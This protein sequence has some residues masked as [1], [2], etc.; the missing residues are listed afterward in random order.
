MEDSI[1]SPAQK[2]AAARFALECRKIRLAIANN[3]GLT[4]FEL[5]KKTKISPISSHLEKME[6]MGL[7]KQENIKEGGFS[8]AVWH[9][10][11]Q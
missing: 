8:S 4:E 9:V 11:P 2:A 5:R 3:P 10:V 1:N 7:V 6:L